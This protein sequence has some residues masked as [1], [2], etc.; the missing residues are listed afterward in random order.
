M[1]LRSKPVPPPLLSADAI[2]IAAD[3]AD[4]FGPGAHAATQELIKHLDAR[5]M[6][7]RAAVYRQVEAILIYGT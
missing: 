4:R 5:G 3:L 2:E 6:M 7:D 1:Q